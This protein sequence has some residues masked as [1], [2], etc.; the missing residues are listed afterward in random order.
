MLPIL[1]IEI[2]SL[3]GFEGLQGG[4]CLHRLLIDIPQPWSWVVFEHLLLFSFM[5]ANHRLS[6]EAP[7]FCRAREEQAGL[8]SEQTC[9]ENPALGA[10][11]HVVAA[12]LCQSPAV[13]H[14][15]SVAPQHPPPFTLP[16]V[17]RYLGKRE[18]GVRKITSSGFFLH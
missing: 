12:R 6:G 1:R 7:S 16:F 14:F 9:W 17:P 13:R 15:L 10:L 5:L 4:L 8:N 2:L 18:R 3:I 11:L